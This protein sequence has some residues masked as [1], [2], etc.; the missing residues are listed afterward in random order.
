METRRI[1]SLDVTVVGVGCNNFGP[2]L[3]AAATAKVVHAALDAGI[4][5]FDT[6][7]LYGD[8]KS[9]EYL[10][11][12]LKGRRKDAIIASK[13]GHKAYGGN[14]KPAYLR[15][16]IEQSLKR[17]GV[18]CID[19]YQ[20]HT[21]DPDVP[22]ADTLG[23]LDEIVRA[24]KARE[25]GC[26]NFSVAQLREAA[27]ATPAGHARFVSV[28][29]QYSLFHRDPEADVLPECERTGMAFLPYFPLAYGL[30]TGKYR[31]GQPIPRG[32]RIA[33]NA[34]YREIVT[35]ENLDIV[36][37]LIAFAERR[38]HTLLDLAFAWLL[39]HKPV[40]SVIAGAT[41]ETQVRANAAAGTWRLS[42]SEL[43]EVDAL[44]P[45]D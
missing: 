7:E 27:K 12:A 24:G 14:A 18:D 39:A 2:R 40:A 29:N 28:Q 8:G 22:I 38:G 31:K 45:V 35:D 3:D 44:V 13:F 37:R 15:K 25:I 33:E 19:L 9:E 36:E 34:R 10:G 21:P 1:G 6:A 11:L 17:L 30:L 32:T 42:A 4:N 20:L 23:V 26:S 5:F 16:A 41:N 43:A